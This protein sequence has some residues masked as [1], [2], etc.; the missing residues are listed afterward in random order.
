MCLNNL[1]LYYLKLDLFVVIAIAFLFN[2]TCVT[3]SLQKK[4]ATFCYN[5]KAKNLIFFA[6]R[7]GRVV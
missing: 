4:S 7:G 5:K 3:E 6:W 2:W 1:I